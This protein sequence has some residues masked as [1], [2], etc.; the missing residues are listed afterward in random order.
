MNVNRRAFKLQAGTC[1]LLPPGCSPRATQDPEHR[2]VVFAVHFD[3]RT[4]GML[5]GLHT[6][7]RDMEFFRELARRC[8][9]AFR[10]STAFGEV[11]SELYL[12][13]ILL[14]LLEEQS[15]PAISP[16]DLKISGII[17]AI[18]TEP[19][20]R[21]SVDALAKTAHLSRSQ[22]TRRF[23]AVT[24]FSPTRFLVRIR[25]ERAKRLLEETDMTLGQIA[26][27]LN[28]RDVYFF[29]RQFSQVTGSPP[30]EYRTI[31]RR[32]AP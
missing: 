16:V 9:A 5:P 2:L 20:R 6:T 29:S 19:G 24:H 3:C 23:C 21:W 14:H 30:G 18:Q 28:Y 15:T 10:K 32:A 31:D 27:A 17:R 11:Q 8:E 25:I 12:R 4:N 13:L 1:L 22:F 7:L 26:D